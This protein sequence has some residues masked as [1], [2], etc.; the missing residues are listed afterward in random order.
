MIQ[1]KLPKPPSNFNYNYTKS[2]KKYGQLNYYE[3]NCN[4]TLLIEKW[5]NSSTTRTISIPKTR[6]LSEIILKVNRLSLIYLPMSPDSQ[7]ALQ[8]RNVIFAEAVTG[9]MNS[10]TYPTIEKRKE[11]IRGSCYRCLRPG[12]Q[13]RDCPDD[14]L[15]IHCGKRNAHHRS[16]CPEKFSIDK[17]E[18]KGEEKP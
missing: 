16:L 6:C 13:S 12:H 7:Q 18:Q 10:R 2:L 8:V 11:V 15:C 4:I 5:L 14:K 3:K 1:A 17:Q 9:Q